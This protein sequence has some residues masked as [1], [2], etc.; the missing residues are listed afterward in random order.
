M[1]TPDP[2]R[3]HDAEQGIASWQ[4]VGAGMAAMYK[5]LM[6]VGMAPDH[7]RDAMV[8]WIGALYKAPRPP[9]ESGA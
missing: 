5:E 4:T 7:A 1:S 8:A 9:S 3:I 2:K 6:Q